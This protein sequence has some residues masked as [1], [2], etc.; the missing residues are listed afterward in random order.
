MSTITT[1]DVTPASPIIGAEV[2]GIDLSEPL[3]PERFAEVEQAL[4][5]HQVLFFREQKALTPEQQIA[6][7]EHFGTLHSHP[8]APHLPGYPALMVIQAD[9]NT[10]R[11]Y[12][13]TWH[14]DV[15][16]DAEPPSVTTLQLHVIPPSGGDTL[17]SSL[18]A[19]YDGLSP[20]IKRL[21]EGLRVSH[22]S[23]HHYRGRYAERG[24]QDAGKVYPSAVHPMVRTHPKTGRRALFVNRIFS[25]RI[26]DLHPAESD[27]LLAFLIN[28]TEKVDYQVRHRW[29]PNDLALWDNRCTNHMAVWDY[30]PHV[31]KGHRV[32]VSGDKPFFKP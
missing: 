24:V 28:H 26:L 1:L 9:G 29:R 4:L 32:T 22:E 14:S 21:V 30:F 13:E 31:R 18:Y 3:T 19:A 17:F 7:A 6:F 2:R 8:A 25:R 10:K 20:D 15:S 5:R 27:A 23:E 16:C 12:G 11:N